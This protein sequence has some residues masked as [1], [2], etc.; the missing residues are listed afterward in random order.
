MMAPMASSTGPVV[1]LLCSDLMMTSS[2]S[3]AAS[4]LGIRFHSVSSTDDAAQALLAGSR[5]LLLIDLATRDLD[6]EDL[7]RKMPEGILT[8]TVAYGPHV[9]TSLLETAA[10]AGIGRVL[11][12]G[13]FHSQH[14]EILRR[15]A[16]QSV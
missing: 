7:P 2:V 4:A 10:G 1:V 14:G 11:S 13:Q 9:H 12:R 15:F 6:V 16:E 5:S 3:S 8:S